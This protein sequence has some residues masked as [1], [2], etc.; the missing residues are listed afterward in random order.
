M[1]I[2]RMKKSRR[3][4]KKSRKP[5]RIG[6]AGAGASIVGRARKNIERE[7][8]EELAYRTKPPVRY[9]PQ[10][11]QQRF[12]AFK[13]A[14]REKMEA[15]RNYNPYST[16]E[17]EDQKRLARAGLQIQMD[18]GIPPPLTRQ[19]SNTSKDIIKTQKLILQRK[20]VDKA[21]E[22]HDTPIYKELDT[23]LRSLRDIN[24][25]IIIDLEGFTVKGISREISSEKK[26]TKFRLTDQE[27]EH[28]AYINRE[29]ERINRLKQDEFDKIEK[30]K[31]ELQSLQTILSIPPPLMNHNRA[32]RHEDDYARQVEEHHRRN[33]ERKAPVSRNIAK[34]QEDITSIRE[35]ELEAIERM[36]DQLDT[37]RQY[38]PDAYFK[39]EEGKKAKENFKY[40]YK[41]K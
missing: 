17:T 29:Q 38:L 12:K 1:P 5:L 11:Q 28:I 27:K 4:T 25:Q 13:E 20:I 36:Q 22:L 37:E 24:V 16:L 23:L 8:K 30:L 9:T 21:R 10:E 3:C 18:K 32:Y 7:Q 35:N 33:R 2:K 31:R 26:Q 15:R 6:G 19:L 14:E 39:S 40:R 41:Y 34:I